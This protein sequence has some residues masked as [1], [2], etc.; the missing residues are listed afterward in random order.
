MK[1]KITVTID[2]EIEI[3]LKEHLLNLRIGNKSKFIE[4]LI[5]TELKNKKKNN[6]T[7]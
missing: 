5:K 2:S 1:K 4:D 3:M 6:E 7:C